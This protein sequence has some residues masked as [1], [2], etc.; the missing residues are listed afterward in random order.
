MDDI[1]IFEGKTFQD[2]IKDIYDNT[3]S[4]KNQLD[5]IILDIVEILD[6]V[7]EI[8][9]VGPTIKDMMDVAVK[10]DEH[11]VKLASVLQRI[12]TKSIG[13]SDEDTFGI[14]DEEKEDLMATLQNTVNE[15]QKDSDKVLNVSKQSKPIV[16]N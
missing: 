4:R 2:L 3:S 13:G 1:E 5:K 8:V 14:S 16:E 6:N 9:L 12:I 7:N 11:L 10:N 15:I